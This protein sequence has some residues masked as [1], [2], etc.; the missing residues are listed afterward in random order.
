MTDTLRTILAGG[1]VLGIMVLLHEWG[2]FIAAKLCGVRVDVF[3]IGFGPRLWGVKRGDTDYR[4]S[5]LPL[6]G[7]V[8]MAGDNPMEERTGAPNEF[9]SRPRWQRCIIAVA[10]PAMNVLLTF[11]IFWGIYWFVGMPVDKYFSNPPD[12][13]AIPQSVTPDPS[14]VLP[15][16][17]ILSVNGVN[18]PTWEKVFAEVDKAKP[19]AP[20]AVAVQRAGSAQTLN[21]KAPENPD[22]TDSA[23]GYPALPAVVDEIAIGYP[24]ER[25]GLKPDDQI[26][27]INGQPVVSWMQLLDQVR[28]SDGRSIHFVAR[29]DGHDVPVDITPVKM[30]DQDG[31][32]AWQVGVQRKSEETYERQGFVQSI[33]DSGFATISSMKGIGQVLGGLFS[34]KVS[35][36]DLQTVVGIAREAGRAAKRG[37][38]PLIELT[39]IISLNLGI[40]NLL[41]IPILDG[42][43]V[44]MLAIEGILR[45]DL[46]L[47]FKERFVQVGLVFLLGFFAFV[48]YNDILRVIQAHH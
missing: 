11:G 1:I 18:T 33:K 36:R 31:Q 10:G 19:G 6:G 5:G 8:R 2:H 41:P 37:P 15:G 26:V 20:L 32:M 13:V 43:H 22:S 29:R 34:G 23:V 16:D 39:A 47:A 21:L 17:R 40:L 30:M 38:M 24:A 14:K 46:S 25:A 45:R 27:S 4:I 7:Y 28:N 35:V 9:L 12:V 48:M 42:G 3:S 44:L